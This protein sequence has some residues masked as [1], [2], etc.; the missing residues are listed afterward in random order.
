MQAQPFRVDQSVRDQPLGRPIE[1]GSKLT[2]TALLGEKIF[3]VF[4]FFGSG[5]EL[6][7]QDEYDLTIA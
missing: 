6:I 3:E 7:V 1:V 4:G 2:V 5:S